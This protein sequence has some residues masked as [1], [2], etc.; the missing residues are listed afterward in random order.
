M[1]SNE[2]NCSASRTINELMNAF[3]NYDDG[4]CLTQK[5]QICFLFNKSSYFRFKNFRKKMIKMAKEL[6][7]N[8]LKDFHIHIFH[9]FKNNSVTPSV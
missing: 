4:E 9:K 1:F 7:F 8:K 6:Y 2:P 5:T 3:I